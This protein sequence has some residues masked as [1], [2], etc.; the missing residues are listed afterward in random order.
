MA[1]RSDSLTNT[2]RSFLTLGA[3]SYGAMAVGLATNVVLARRLGAEQ[4]GRLALMLMASQVL[5]LVAVNWSHI[6]FVRFG[7]REFVSSG[8][9][10]ETLSTRLGILMPAA[11]LGAIGLVFARQPLA[12]YLGIPPIGVWLI[13][14]HFIAACALS[15]I[16]AVFQ[17]RDQMA[18]YGV[19]LFLDKT[20]MLAFVMA[21]PAAWVGNPL[22]ALACYAASSLSVAI[23]GLSVVGASTL[24]LALP[25]RAAYRSMVRFSVPLLVSSWA[26]FFGTNWLDLVILKWYVPMASVG[27][28][29]LAFQLAAVVQQI[30]VIF[31][32]LLWADHHVHRAAAAVLVA[33]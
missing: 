14:V 28:Y 2:W 18:R 3:G 20:V 25:S 1:E 29:S 22:G 5:L 8:A 9:L 4:Y 33:R 16:G 26:G 27:A 11:G 10:T 19:C 7:S 23:W 12:I 32:T 21:L 17:A 24:R 6:G 13:L 15:L 30:A 31:S